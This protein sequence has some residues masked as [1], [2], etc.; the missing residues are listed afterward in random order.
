MSAEHAPE[1]DVAEVYDEDFESASSILAKALKKLRAKR[2]ETAEY[3]RGLVQELETARLLYSEAVIAEREVERLL[4]GDLFTG[5]HQDPDEVEAEIEADKVADALEAAHAA[6][7]EAP[8]PET[9][10]DP[11]AEPPPEPEPPTAPQVEA[12]PPPSA[13]AV[14]KGPDRAAALAASRQALDALLERLRAALD[15]LWTENPDGLTAKMIGE[16]LG[17]TY[18]QA[19]RAVHELEKAGEVQ[20][21]PRRDKAQKLVLRPGA[22]LPTP[23]FTEKQTA[24]LATITEA[25]KDGVAE[26]S[27]GA[28]AKHLGLNPGSVAQIVYALEHKGGLR[29][30]R[31][32][33]GHNAGRYRVAGLPTPAPAAPSTI[34]RPLTADQLKLVR[35]ELD[36]G[37]ML[38][39]IEAMHGIAAD[40]AR[41]AL[42]QAAH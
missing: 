40:A 5:A 18:D 2:R 25:A 31:P 11:E 4:K 32:G 29:I 35:K 22:S 19:I 3:V 30:E 12:D 24:V 21:I 1:A 15:G 16:A 41:E 37:F 26:I 34:S 33:D 28:I 20:Y 36:R 8:E 17:V 9:L 6:Q 38:K 13:Y 27:L 23:Q 39:E 10:G 42:R 7:V 14:S